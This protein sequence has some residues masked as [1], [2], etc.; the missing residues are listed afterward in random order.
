MNPISNRIAVMN[1]KKK[2][3]TVYIVSEHAPTAEAEG[4]ANMEFYEAS[5]NITES[6]S[7]RHIMIITGDFRAK[8]LLAGMMIFLAMLAGTE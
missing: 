1:L 3:K 8:L 7:N 5:K 4:E 2:R 6:I